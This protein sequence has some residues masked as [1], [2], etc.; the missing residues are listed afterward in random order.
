MLKPLVVL[1]LLFSATSALADPATCRFAVD[2]TV[3][4][5][6]PCDVVRE[7]N[8]DFRFASPDGGWFGDVILWEDG[9]AGGAW[10]GAYGS[11]HAQNVMGQLTLTDGC[12]TNASITLCTR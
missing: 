5:D 7:A 9:Q 6:G 8:G 12:W 2:G 3:L 10:N 1:A 11:D 4:I